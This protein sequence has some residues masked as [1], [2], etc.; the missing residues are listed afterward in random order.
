MLPEDTREQ[1]GRAA[2]ETALSHTWD[3][4]A[5][6]VA[7]IYEELLQRRPEERGRNGSFPPPLSST[8]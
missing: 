5:A 7:L 8:I 4:A 6:S 3:E 1:M 2:R